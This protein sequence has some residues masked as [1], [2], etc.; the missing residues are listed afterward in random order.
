[1][2]FKIPYGLWM[3]AEGS[4][5]RTLSGTLIVIPEIEGF[6]FEKPH[7]PELQKEWVPAKLGKS[8]VYKGIVNVFIPFTLNSSVN[9]E[10]HNLDFKVTYT[11][12][13]GAGKLSTHNNQIV[14]TT[15]NVSNNGA[16]GTAIP[17]PSTMDVDSDFAVGPPTRP[18]LGFLNFVYGYFYGGIGLPF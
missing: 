17:T 4:L 2:Q 9:S 15:T 13:Y 6:T 7:F 10:N 3:G 11:P 5:A 14:S 12:G 18:S 16:R 1:M 8:L